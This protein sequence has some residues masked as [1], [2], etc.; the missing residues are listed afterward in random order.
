M[1]AQARKALRAALCGVKGGPY[2]KSLGV[3]LSFSVAKYRL[4]NSTADQI[5]QKTF[6]KRSKRKEICDRPTAGQLLQMNSFQL[7]KNRNE[8]RSSN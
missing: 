2:S 5:T 3:F 8:P 7:V 6:L 4:S 1:A